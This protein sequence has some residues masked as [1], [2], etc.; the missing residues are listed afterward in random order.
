MWRDLLHRILPSDSVLMGSERL[1]HADGLSAFF[2]VA[3]CAVLPEGYG[4]N[5]PGVCCAM[6][7]ERVP[8]QGRRGD[9]LLRRM[10]PYL[11]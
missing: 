8:S 4:H 10:H 1:D 11:T 3:S 5:W 2:E 9:A 6:A 7:R